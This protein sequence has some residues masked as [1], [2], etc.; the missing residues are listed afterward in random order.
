[1]GTFVAASWLDSRSGKW[2]GLA[3]ILGSLVCWL[4]ELHVWVLLQGVSGVGFLAGHVTR[5]RP[6]VRAILVLLGLWCGFV[7]LAALICLAV[8]LPVW[9]VFALLVGETPKVIADF[10]SRYLAAPALIV[11]WLLAGKWFTARAR[12]AYAIL[13]QRQ[14][15]P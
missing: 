3:L 8:A 2:I 1:M 10:G 5:S 15:S 7:Y 6:R 12:A 11:A 14:P 9:L 4:L 13:R